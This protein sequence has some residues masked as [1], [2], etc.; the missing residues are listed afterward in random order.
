[1]D[2]SHNCSLRGVM[3]EVCENLFYLIRSF[4]L[5]PFINNPGLPT[6]PLINECRIGTNVK[7]PVQM[8]KKNPVYWI[9]LTISWGTKVC[10]LMRNHCISQKL[11]QLLAAVFSSESLNLCKLEN[12]KFSSMLSTVKW[13]KCD[14]IMF[15]DHIFQT[16]VTC[17]SLYVTVFGKCSNVFNYAH[18]SLCSCNSWHMKLSCSLYRWVHQLTKQKYFSNIFILT[19]KNVGYIILW[20]N[21]C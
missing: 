4:L 11:G 13:P 15:C 21:T 6:N 1:M 16:K 7:I 8:D 5:N 14:H 20:Y 2:L 9:I 10:R 18:C 17:V 12:Y 19:N 3:S